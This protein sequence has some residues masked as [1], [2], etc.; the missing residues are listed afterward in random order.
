[1]NKALV[2]T[3]TR[4]GILPTL[5][6]LSFI[7]CM[8]LARKLSLLL[9]CRLPSLSALNI[10]R[11]DINADDVQALTTEFNSETGALPQLRSLIMTI[12]DDFDSGV[13][14]NDNPCRFQEL[15]FHSVRKTTFNVISWSAMQNLRRL[16]LTNVSKTE[17]LKSLKEL[18]PLKSLVLNECTFGEIDLMILADIVTTCKL[19]HLDLSQNPGISG[20]LSVLLDHIYPSLDTLFLSDCELTRKDLKSLPLATVNGRLPKLKQLDISSN[21]L[22]PDS[23]SFFSNDCK[24]DNLISLD[25]TDDAILSRL[26]ETRGFIV[27]LSECL[28]SGCLRSLQVLSFTDNLESWNINIECEHL[29]TIR[30]N[31]FNTKCMGSIVSAL[32]EGMLPALR[33]VCIG[34]LYTDS[35]YVAILLPYESVKILT[36]F[37]VFC[38]ETFFS[39]NPFERRCYLCRPHKCNQS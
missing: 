4:T 26:T 11:T 29:Q 30:I 35:R 28:S 21:K 12:P 14:F 15:F 33:N 38:H 37:D 36:Q 22:W 16:G 18:V 7:D 39:T 3:F 10:I 20:K 13:L 9:Q 25:I 31:G 34:S 5:Q 24:W 23:D 2:M 32:E 17:V 19:T 8:G 27:E 6:T 1:M